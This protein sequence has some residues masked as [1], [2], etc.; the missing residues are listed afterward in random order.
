LVENNKVRRFAIPLQGE[1]ANISF[2]GT[3]CR[4][5]REVIRLCRSAQSES[6]AKN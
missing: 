4:A 5:G 2:A 6:N 1:Q 3:C